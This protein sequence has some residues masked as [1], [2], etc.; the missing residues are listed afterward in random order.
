MS[1]IGLIISFIIAIIVMIVAISKFKVHPFIALMGISLS[2]S[3]SFSV[4]SLALSS[5]RPAVL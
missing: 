1:G 5:R 4:P 3:S 2:V